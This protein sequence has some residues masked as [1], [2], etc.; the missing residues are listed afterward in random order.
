MPMM[1][2][3]PPCNTKSLLGLTISRIKASILRGGRGR[4]ERGEGTERKE[5]KRGEGGVPSRGNR[6]PPSI[7][8]SSLTAVG[9]RRTPP[10]GDRKRRGGGERE[11]RRGRDERKKDGVADTPP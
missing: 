8:A 9:S 5:G 1:I 11:E 3:D 2:I 6:H 10:E 4:G 7:V